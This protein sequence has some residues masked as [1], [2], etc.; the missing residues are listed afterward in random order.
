[1]RSSHVRIDA[2][3]NSAVSAVMP[4]LTQASLAATS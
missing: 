3:A 1:M 4:T 2:T